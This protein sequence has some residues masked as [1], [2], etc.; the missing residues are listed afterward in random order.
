MSLPKLFENIRPG[1]P[2]RR[3]QDA[4]EHS[5]SVVDGKRHP[6]VA[7]YAMYSTR[8]S[9][10]SL[11]RNVG[12]W[13]AGYRRFGDEFEA[14]LAGVDSQKPTELAKALVANL[15]DPWMVI[16]RRFEEFTADE[17][18]WW[19]RC[20]SKDYG[21]FLPLILRS[22]VPDPA[23]AD[24]VGYKLRYGGLYA[25][26]D[27]LDSWARAVHCTIMERYGHTTV[28]T[29]SREPTLAAVTVDDLLALVRAGVAPQQ[30][31]GA[32]KNRAW[33][34]NGLRM[35]LTEGVPLEYAMAL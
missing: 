23:L 20:L 31:A 25:S 9:M 28:S 29:I 14:A 18:H 13:N 16:G 2:S 21:S 33:T 19:S 32:V 17:Q 15:P 6:R 22:S 30:Y 4:V 5:V 8:W 10:D 24:W 34:M 11:S 27:D 12:A 35:Y 1:K 7:L 26:A 3:D